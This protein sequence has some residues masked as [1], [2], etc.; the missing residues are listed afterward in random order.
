MK[1]TDER[2]DSVWKNEIKWN[3][4]L[5]Q[6]KS[7]TQLKPPFWEYNSASLKY[8]LINKNLLGLQLLSIK[9]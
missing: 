3:N 2:L 8:I 7:F 1:N 4:D 6:P 9:Y 5:L